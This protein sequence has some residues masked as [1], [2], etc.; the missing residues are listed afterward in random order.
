[1]RGPMQ[2]SAR[3]VLAWL[4]GSLTT[5]LLLLTTGALASGDP[6]TDDV[7]RYVPY[8]GVLSHDGVPFT[9]GASLMLRLYDG[10]AAVDAVWS[11][12]QTV[13][14]YAGEFTALLGSGTG[15]GVAAL[16]TVLAAA[17]DLYLGV[18]VVTPGGE[19]PLTERKR[20]VPLPYAAWAAEGTDFLVGDQLVLASSKT[21]DA[22]AADGV[23][24]VRDDSA[25]TL[26]M[27]GD[28]LAST[29]KLT[30]GPTS[31]ATRV[32]GGL[33]LGSGALAFDSDSF[34]AA[35]IRRV[36]TRTASG[37]LTLV[38]PSNGA[39][40]T[41][42]SDVTFNQ[43]VAG[44]AVTPGLDPAASGC[45]DVSASSSSSTATTVSCPVG[46]VPVG[47]SFNGNGTNAGLESLR[48]C[49]PTFA[50]E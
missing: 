32:E 35:P 27:D 14:C 6:S 49:T 39:S 18:S 23:V 16:S 45:T 5:A 8:R 44:L 19:V 40:V 22:G 12:R 3:F 4:G 46:T 38:E 48:C 47:G 2:R 33:T 9:G 34:I 37:E 41:F 30:V 21:V 1:M 13:N 42:H 43:D 50:V 7:P 20:L 31:G 17:K 25:E 29:A 28:E 15:D 26:A 10:A 24:V 11:E 36:L